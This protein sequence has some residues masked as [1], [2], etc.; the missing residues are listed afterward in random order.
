MLSISSLVPGSYEESHF[1]DLWLPGMHE[2]LQCHCQGYLESRTVNEHNPL[3]CLCRR[4]E[5]ATA[6]CQIRLLMQNNEKP[7][8]SD[9]QVCS[10]KNIEHVERF[11]W[12]AHHSSCKK[13]K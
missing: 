7:W 11:A 4:G 3:S 8:R 6:I 5:G 9:F 12:L 13:L 10:L 2:G 1:L